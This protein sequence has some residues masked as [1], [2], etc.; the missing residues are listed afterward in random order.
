MKWRKCQVLKKGKWINSDLE[1][2]QKGDT[3]RLFEADGTPVK[4]NLGNDHY[5]ASKDAIP[6]EPNG[7]F[8]VE[9]IQ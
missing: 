1:K 7:N 5:V 9:V 6:C 3:F 2:V 8:S 4:D